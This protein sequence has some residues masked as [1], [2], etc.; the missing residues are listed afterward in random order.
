MGQTSSFRYCERPSTGY[1]Q[2]LS[3]EI[4]FENKN[5]SPS[6]GMQIKEKKSSS[7]SNPP[8]PSDSMRESKVSHNLLCHIATAEL[9]RAH[10]G[11]L[12]P[13]T[14]PEISSPLS[15]SDFSWAD[16]RNNLF[17]CKG[18]TRE[19]IG[20]SKLKAMSA[21]GAN[22]KEFTTHGGRSALMFAVL[23]QDLHFVKRLV[24]DGANVMEENEHGETALGLAKSLPSQDIY[25]F[26]LKSTA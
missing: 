24:T 17:D 12:I 4:V 26:L 14:S 15:E 13:L 8:Y 18:K 3:T 20:M 21:C 11:T 19:E 25:N 7:I 5:D 2:R 1:R 10:N 22:V 6:P 23:S 16:S 9:V